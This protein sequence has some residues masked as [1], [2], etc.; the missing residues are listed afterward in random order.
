MKADVGMLPARNRLAWAWHMLGLAGALAPMTGLIYFPFGLVGPLII[1]RNRF[2]GSVLLWLLVGLTGQAVLMLVLWAGKTMLTQWNQT[3]SDRLHAP[4]VVG[5]LVVAI[6]FRAVAIAVVA[7]NLQLTPIIELSY[8]LRAGAIA[9]FIALLFVAILVS[10]IMHHRKLTRS[11][12]TETLKLQYVSKQMT[13]R[14]KVLRDSIKF[15]IEKSVTPLMEQLKKL[16]EGDSKGDENQVVQSIAVRIIDDELRPLSHRVVSEPGFDSEFPLNRN[17]DLARR[18]VFPHRSSISTLIRPILVALL[19][20]FLAASQAI[21]DFSLPE[22]LVITAF[23]FFLIA[24]ILTVVR[25]ILRDWAPRTWVGIPVVVALNVVSIGIVY[26]ASAYFENAFTRPLGEAALVAIPIISIVSV[27]FGL[28]ETTARRQEE[29]LFELNAQLL[30]AVSALRQREFIA[31]KN[32]SYVIH[33]SIQGALHASLMRLAAAERPSAELVESI[34]SDILNATRKVEDSASDY[35][36]LVDT[37]SEIVDLWQGT[38][39]VTWTLDYR[40]VSLLASSSTA[41]MSVAEIVRE[42]VVNSVRHGKALNTS[43]DIS[44][45][46]GLVLVTV[47]DNGLGVPADVELGLGSHMMDE[48]CL[49]WSR[50]NNPVGTKVEARISTT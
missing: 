50:S 12:E 40:T 7:H 18:I 2:G 15:E 9:Q 24:S 43:V 10:A 26:W 37:L 28:A 11:L 47:T 1:D 29:Q 5:V 6:A 44:A 46:D 42:T 13:E 19:V 8:R 48:L 38:C 41:A 14:I 32:L 33:G 25:W 49:T 21:R 27:L 20:G 45:Q 22:I 3:E 35:T 4:F 17:D 16:A 36:Y 31:R 34:H 30:R 23:I 39:D